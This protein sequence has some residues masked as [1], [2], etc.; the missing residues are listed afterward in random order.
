MLETFE[1][2]ELDNYYM[3]PNGD[4]QN[5][6]LT[7]EGIENSPNNSLQIFNRY[8]V[9]MKILSFS[10]PFIFEKKTLRLSSCRGGKPMNSNDFLLKGQA[11]KAA[12]TELGPGMTLTLAPQY[13]AFLRITR[14]ILNVRQPSPARITKSTPASCKKCRES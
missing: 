6:V 11:D 3:T 5:D 7:I 9:S 8:G 12:V 2:I 10:F 13:L 4:G 14:Q 1:T